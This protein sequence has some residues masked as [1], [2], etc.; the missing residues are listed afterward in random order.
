M[1]MSQ[2]CRLLRWDKGRCER[3]GGIEKMLSWI[4]I[5]IKWRIQK[6][7]RRERRERTKTV[8]QNQTRLKHIFVLFFFS[9][10]I[11]LSWSKISRT[12][13]SIVLCISGLKPLREAKYNKKE[14]DE[15]TNGR[16]ERTA[17]TT[18]FLKRSCRPTNYPV[19]NAILKIYLHN[20]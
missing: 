14:E 16:E 17:D 19:L 12:E 20:F 10:L 2:K 8:E 6:R 9:H 1:E 11:I 7:R 3:I 15:R 18:M 5:I 4:M 13:R